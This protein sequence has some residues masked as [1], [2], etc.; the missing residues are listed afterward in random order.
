MAEYE[1]PLMNPLMDCRNGPEA[2]PRPPATGMSIISGFFFRNVSWTHNCRIFMHTACS[3]QIRA[4]GAAV[5]QVRL[6]R[7]RSIAI[8]STSKCQGYSRGQPIITSTSISSG[9]PLS[10]EATCAEIHASG[11]F[12]RNQQVSA[13]QGEE[14]WVGEGRTSASCTTSTNTRATMVMMHQATICLQ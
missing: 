5:R 8:V 3:S 11:S 6:A 10:G 7:E 2:V 4:H 13:G 9:S 1:V 12:C 14:G